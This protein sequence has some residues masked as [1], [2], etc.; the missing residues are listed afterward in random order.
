MSLEPKYIYKGYNLVY[1][2]YKHNV[3]MFYDLND[4]PVDLSCESVENELSEINILIDLVFESEENES[5]Q[6]SSVEELSKVMKSL[7]TH[8][9]MYIKQKTVSMELFKQ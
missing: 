9:K 7:L 1:G 3:Q 5:L 4:N 6:E 2:L 8:W